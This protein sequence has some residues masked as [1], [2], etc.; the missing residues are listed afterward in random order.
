NE[1]GMDPQNEVIYY[2]KLLKLG[3]LKGKSWGDK[4]RMV[5]LQQGSGGLFASQEPSAGPR[6]ATRGL[7]STPKTRISTRLTT[8]HQSDDLL[9]LHS[10]QDDSEIVETEGATETEIYIPQYNRIPQSILRLPLSASTANSTLGL[11]S[12]SRS[13]PVVSA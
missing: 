4:W 8:Q 6:P 11:D 2:G 12:S 10:H 7:P 9:T 13:G 3:T 5:K 1:R